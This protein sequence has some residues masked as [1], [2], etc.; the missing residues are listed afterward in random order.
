MKTLI[1]ILFL[2]LLSS[3]SWSQSIEDLMQVCEVIGY[4]SKTEE[5]GACV[6]ALRGKA[7]LNKIVELKQQHRK[8]AEAKFA[9][10]HERQQRQHQEQLNYY[11]QQQQYEEQQAKIQKEKERIS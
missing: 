7:K 4:E 10:M 5:F 9:A 6:L 3:P 2:S 1:T 8:A 11:R